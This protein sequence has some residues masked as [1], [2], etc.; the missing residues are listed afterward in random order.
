MFKVGRPKGYCCR[1][2]RSKSS[3]VIPKFLDI[4][5]KNTIIM[6]LMDRNANALNLA[7]TA[8]PAVAGSLATLLFL[9]LLTSP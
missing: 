7:A 4:Q 6:P 3:P 1:L 5:T 2:R 8:G 9:L